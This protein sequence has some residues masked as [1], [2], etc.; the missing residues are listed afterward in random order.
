MP[1]EHPDRRRLAIATVAATLGLAGAARAQ[2][3]RNTP[4]RGVEL[5]IAHGAATIHQE[6]SFK[7]GRDRVYQ[8]LTDARLFDKVMAASAAAK[9]MKGAM[10]PA[11]IAAEPG[12]AF[13]LFGGYI[14][15]RQIELT[16]G[17]RIIQAWHANS[18]APHVFSIAR[19]ELS[20]HAG[21]TRL[22]FDHTGFPA[23]Q[24]QHLAVGWYDN[25]WTPLAKVLA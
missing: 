9:Q 14:S 2:T 13:S 10:A 7:A 5:G 4:A 20:E 25:Y 15:G 19:F 22:V 24:A 6:T 16:P 17:E 21:G 8:A 23:D 3:M 1:T 11:E 12:G 18:W